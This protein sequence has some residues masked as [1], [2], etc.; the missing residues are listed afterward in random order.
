MFPPYVLAPL[1]RCKPL[2]AMSHLSSTNKSLISCVFLNY[3]K[4]PALI[5]SNRLSTSRSLYQR[6]RVFI[7]II[8]KCNAIILALFILVLLNCFHCRINRAEQA[9]L[10]LHCCLRST[11]ALCNMNVNVRFYIQLRCSGSARIHHPKSLAFK[12]YRD[13]C[14]RLKKKQKNN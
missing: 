8:Q 5:Q 4:A 3:L 1:D 14:L 7:P 2:L 10:R 9:L 11:A 12:H 6:S 13:S